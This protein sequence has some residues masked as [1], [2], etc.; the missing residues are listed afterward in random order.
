MGKNQRNILLSVLTLALVALGAWLVARQLQQDAGIRALVAIVYRLPENEQ[1]KPIACSRTPLA[2]GPE[3][4]ALQEIVLRLTKP[5]Q[6]AMAFCLL[7]DYP[8]A[9]AAYEQSAASGDEGSALQVYFLQARQGDMPA[10]KL[11]L[12]SVQFSDKE[13]QG[14]FTSVINLKLNIDVLPVAQRMAE[15]YPSDP[16]SWKLWLDA[17]REYERASNW[18]SALDVYLEA[19]RVQEKIGVRIGRSSFEVGAGN[20]Y[21]TRLEPR[22]LNRALSCYNGA[23]ADM[24]FLE[25]GKPSYVFLS[26]GQVYLGLRPTYTAS[27]ALQEFLHSL[28]LDPK[29]YW[30][31]Q[32]IAGVYLGD[33]KNYPLAE[34]YIN[35]AIDLNPNLP[36][37]YLTRGDMYRQQG[38]LQSAIAAYQEAL[39]RQPGYQAALN[40][41]AA[42]QTELQKRAP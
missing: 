23:I 19:F 9:L 34:H 5:I 25:V 13:L 31:M 42:V 21:Q 1:L 38:D 37:A 30:A 11:A 39:T 27:Q 15:L 33:L 36:Y 12:S 14:F 10:A 24:D 29:N 17:A 28:E 16:D 20:I 2:D 35:L 7:G 18:Q 22:D 26:R 4:A 3:K 40:R 32:A 41:L 8:S 6:R